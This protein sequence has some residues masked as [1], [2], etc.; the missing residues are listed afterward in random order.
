MI[1]KKGIYLEK[2][3]YKNAFTIIYYD[4]VHV[5]VIPIN[6]SIMPELYK[7]YSGTTF[8]DKNHKRTT[9]SN[10]ITCWCPSGLNYICEDINDF[11]LLDIKF[12]LDEMLEK[13]SD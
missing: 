1:K 11:P 9:I 5:L 3:P 4:G 2:I 12:I 7:K 8:I 10:I 6:N 13:W